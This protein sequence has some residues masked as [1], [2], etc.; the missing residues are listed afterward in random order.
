MLR[1]PDGSMEDYIGTVFGKMEYWL[2]RPEIEVRE[3]DDS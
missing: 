3:V 1:W 2:D